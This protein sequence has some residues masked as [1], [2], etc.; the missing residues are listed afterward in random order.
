MCVLEFLTNGAKRPDEHARV[1][2]LRWGGLE[3][4][5]FLLAVVRIGDIRVTGKRRGDDILSESGR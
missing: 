1:A 2:A 3:A 5:H 4:R